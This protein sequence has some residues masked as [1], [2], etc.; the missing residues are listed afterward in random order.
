[1][2]CFT[3]F[4]QLLVWDSFKGLRS[5]KLHFSCSHAQKKLEVTF[6]SVDAVDVDLSPSGKIVHIGKSGTEVWSPVDI[7]IFGLLSEFVWLS[8]A[9]S[10][11]WAEVQSSA[12]LSNSAPGDTTLKL[13]VS[14]GADELINFS[15]TNC[16]EVVGQFGGHMKMFVL[17]NFTKLTLKKSKSHVKPSKPWDYYL[18]H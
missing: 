9:E 10:V 1:M 3:L 11:K 14:C 8:V 2:Q 5:T 4:C 17:V 13:S 12:G 6:F 16:D 7:Q 18:C 15:C